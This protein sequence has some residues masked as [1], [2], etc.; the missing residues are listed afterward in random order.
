MAAKKIGYAQS[1]VQLQIEQQTAR[2]KAAGCAEVFS[3][4]EKVTPP[5]D[6]SGIRA[7]L[8]VL[9]TGDTLLV[10]DVTRLTRSVETLADF[11]HELRA[12][13]VRVEELHASHYNEAHASTVRF[14]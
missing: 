3:D 10:P 5:L 12:R 8:A 9:Q 14:H 2:L 4:T 7:A 11:I 6:R 13:G 1:N